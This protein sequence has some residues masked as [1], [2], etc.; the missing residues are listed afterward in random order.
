VQA[1]GRELIGQHFQGIHGQHYLMRL[2][3]HPSAGLQL[4]ATNYLAD[5]AGDNPERLAELTPY[6]VRVLSGVNRGRVAKARIF[7]F[8][9]QEALKHESAARIVNEILTRQSLTIAIGDKALA[10]EL[11]V[12]IQRTYPEIATPIRVIPPLQRSPQ[13]SSTPR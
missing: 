5:Y 7:D 2:S 6:F 10:L 12:Q 8:L 1:F 13:L 11:M 4:F 9:R 3:E